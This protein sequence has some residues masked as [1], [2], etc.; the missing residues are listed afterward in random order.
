MVTA[1]LKGAAE[2][3]HFQLVYDGVE[4]GAKLSIQK[5]ENTISLELPETEETEIK[6][7]EDLLNALFDLSGP[8]L[9]SDFVSKIDA[10]YAPALPEAIEKEPTSITEEE[11]TS[12]PENTEFAYYNI[13]SEQICLSSGEET[14]GT[15]A[16]I[17]KAAVVVSDTSLANGT[18][19]I[20]QYRGDYG[21]GVVQEGAVVWEVLP[22]E[23]ADYEDIAT[24]IYCHEEYLEL[25]FIYIEGEEWTLIEQ[26]YKQ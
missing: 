8:I 16:S 25:D 15:P 17:S 3:R 22:A 9:K 5:Q 26:L 13:I 2:A 12:A 10:M 24:I 18:E 1:E 4:N 20:Y 7:Q 21:Y 14:V 19:I 6:T 23:Y 11:E